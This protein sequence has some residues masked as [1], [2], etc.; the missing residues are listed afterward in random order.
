MSEAEKH[1]VLTTV[2]AIWAELMG[3][4]SGKMDDSFFEW[5]G[6]SILATQIIAAIDMQF[7]IALT[8]EEFYQHPTITEL[9]DYLIRKAK[10]KLLLESRDEQDD[11]NKRTTIRL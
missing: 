2:H 11:K 3:E 10:I 8:Q 1:I 6:N 4:D 9:S 5:G 7:G